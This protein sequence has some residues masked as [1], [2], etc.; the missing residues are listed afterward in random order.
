MKAK[1]LKEIL[2]KMPDDAEVKVVLR[3]RGGNYEKSIPNA[4]A[5][6][7]VLSA[8]GDDFNKIVGKVLLYI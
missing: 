8:P 7:A 6:M 5:E 3:Y 2:V 1:E 4:C